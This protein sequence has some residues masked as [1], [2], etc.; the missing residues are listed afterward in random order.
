MM[1]FFMDMTQMLELPN[2]NC[3][4]KPWTCDY[5]ETLNSS[6]QQKPACI[7]MMFVKASAG[8]TWV[9]T[10]PSTFALRVRLH[11]ACAH[12][13]CTNDPNANKQMT[14]IPSSAFW[15]VVIFPRG[16]FWLRFWIVPYEVYLNWPQEEGTFVFGQHPKNGL[17]TLS[18]LEF[19]LVW[20][21]NLKSKLS[22][23]S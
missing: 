15:F 2:V 22:N 7:C 20:H 21:L 8:P 23:P 14:T 17:Q 4:F 16:R 13:P 6:S 18:T 11:Y 3:F 9:L 19:F 1:Q 10:G 5:I 12:D